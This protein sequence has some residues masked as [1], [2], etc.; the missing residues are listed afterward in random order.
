M[1]KMAS[2]LTANQVAET[3]VDNTDFGCLLD[4]LVLSLQNPL[5]RGE[6]Y[7]ANPRGQLGLNTFFLLVHPGLRYSCDVHVL[8]RKEYHAQSTHSGR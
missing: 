8:F 1:N 2:A 3:V 6:E 7:V 5:E 4:H